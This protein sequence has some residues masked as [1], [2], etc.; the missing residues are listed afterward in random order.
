MPRPRSTRDRDS[1]KR[2]KG[3]HLSDSAPSSN[4]R[5][6]TKRKRDV[7][8]DVPGDEKL[9]EFLE[10]MQPPSRS[11]TWANGDSVGGVDHGMP[12]DLIVEVAE[13]IGRAS[14]RERVSS[15]V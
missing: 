14:C 10:A 11:K 8:E 5:N 9:Q 13:E 6:N 3:Q 15:P 2:G 12:K 1:L 4:S 7:G